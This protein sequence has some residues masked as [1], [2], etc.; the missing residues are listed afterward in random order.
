VPFSLPTRKVP[1]KARVLRRRGG[2]W[3]AGVG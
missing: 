2:C 3:G 1:C